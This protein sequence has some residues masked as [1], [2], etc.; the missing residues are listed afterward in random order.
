MGSF[1]Q[2][3]VLQFSPSYSPVHSYMAL[4]QDG[5]S[6][7]FSNNVV[8]SSASGT[9]SWDGAAASS[10]EDD[11][12]IRAEARTVAGAVKVKK[13]VAG[14][15]Q[16]QLV[17]PWQLADADSRFADFYGVEIHYK[18]AH[19]SDAGSPPSTSSAPRQ[20]TVDLSEVSRDIAD[21]NNPPPAILLH[22]FGASLFSFERI[23]RPL[24]LLLRSHVL[25]FDRPAFGLTSRASYPFTKTAAG[26]K[27]KAAE[28]GNTSLLNPYSLGFSSA[29]ALSFIDLL[30]S[31][32]AIL[33]G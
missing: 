19:P 15:D 11:A 9:A 31:R 13:A 17:D 4:K 28:K 26:A 20:A 1:G 32:Q 3:A 2:S 21:S 18:V 22:G 12:D 25:A 27:E 7:D 6:M 33:V 10:W 16:S 8:C 24:S 5:R 14:V 23:M 30:K 29:A